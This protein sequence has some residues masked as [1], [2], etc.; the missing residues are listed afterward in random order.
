MSGTWSYNLQLSSGC[1]NLI[2]SLTYVGF[3]LSGTT[4]LLRTKRPVMELSDKWSAFQ[5]FGGTVERMWKKF[6]HVRGN[7][8]SYHITYHVINPAEA[9][10]P[11]F[12]FQAVSL[13][14]LDWQLKKQG[15]CVK[16]FVPV[17]PSWPQELGTHVLFLAWIRKE[18]IKAI[19]E[20]AI[21][22]GGA[23]PARA[24]DYNI[25]NTCPSIK[26]W[27]YLIIFIT[28]TKCIICIYS[29]LHDFWVQVCLCCT[30]WPYPDSFPPLYQ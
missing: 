8:S 28:H 14:K 27:V 9:C 3:T 7:D 21:H 13:C 10:T 19:P 4:L 25:C 12:C 16:W 5:F 26:Y 6:V 17:G 30:T 22:S 11:L 15:K 24:A 29:C 1:I 23:P 20:C 18:E 2:F